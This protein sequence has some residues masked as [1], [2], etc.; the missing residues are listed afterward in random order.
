M[1]GSDCPVTDDPVTVDSVT[2]EL[3]ASIRP[4]APSELVAVERALPMVSPVGH[5]ERLAE[6]YAGQVLYLIAWLGACPVGHILVHWRGSTNPILHPILARYGHHPYFED[7]FVRPEARSGGIGSRLLAEAEQAATSRGHRRVGLA[8]AVDNVRARALYDR[9][10]YR[11]AGFNQFQSRWERLDAEG[12]IQRGLEL[13]VY[14]VK[15]TGEPVLPT[16]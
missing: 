3:L 5:A 10:G 16:G 9:Q 13:C 4:L 8:V 6:Q 15:E 14:L 7:L 1:V 12:Q 11:D 2:D